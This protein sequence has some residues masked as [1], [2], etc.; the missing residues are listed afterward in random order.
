[1]RNVAGRSRIGAFAE[2]V[3][4]RIRA[5]ILRFL[6]S[7]PPLRDYSHFTYRYYLT[8]YALSI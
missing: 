8:V 5:E 6:P 7:Q 2:A 3:A 1:M 4:G